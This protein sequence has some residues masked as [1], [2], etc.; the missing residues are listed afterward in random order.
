MKLRYY[1]VYDMNTKQQVG[2]LSKWNMT[3]AYAQTL[4]YP[5]FKSGRWKVLKVI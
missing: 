5:N 1:V 4:Y 3:S 2:V